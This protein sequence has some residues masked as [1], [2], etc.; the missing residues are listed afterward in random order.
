MCNADNSK[1]YYYTPSDFVKLQ[2]VKRKRCCSCKKLID[3]N[4]LCLKFERGRYPNSDIEENIYMDEVPLAPWYMCEE[5][6][7]MFF[8]F[9]S[10][11]FCINLGDNMAENLRDYWEMNGFIPDKYR[12]LYYG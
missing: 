12:D 1:W 3:I 4:A 6:G 11:G 10:L 2:T 7:D 8:N 9:D 5:C